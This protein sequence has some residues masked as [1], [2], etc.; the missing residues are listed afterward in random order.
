MKYIRAVQITGIILLILIVG[1]KAAVY[2]IPLNSKYNLGKVSGKYS[3]SRYL[4]RNGVVLR[5]FAGSKSRFYTWTPLQKISP[6]LINAALSGEDRNFMNHRGVYYP[7]ILRAFFQN[8][9]GGKTISGGSTITMQ[10]SKILNP[11]SRTLLNKLK[12]FFISQQIEASFDKVTILE[13]YLNLLP[14]GNGAQGVQA[15][16]HVYFQKDVSRL[17]SAESALLMI[18]PRAVSFYN[19]FRHLKRVR[20]QQKRLLEAMY[21]NGYLDKS[22]LKWSLMEEVV[23]K[24]QTPPFTAPHFTEYIRKKLLKKFPDRHVEEVTTTLDAEIQKYINGV[25]R[26]QLSKF[27]NLGMNNISCI[28]IRNDTSE[29]VG[30]VGNPYFNTENSSQIDGVLALRQPGSTLKPFTYLLE[31]INGATA[32]TIYPDVETRFELG[33]NSAY[34]PSNYSGKYLGPVTMRKALASSLN[35]PALYALRHGGV[36]NLIEVLKKAGIEDISDKPEVYGLGL[37]LGNAHVSLLSLATAYSTLARR[38]VLKKAV[39]VKKIKFTDGKLIHLESTSEKMVFPSPHVDII[40]DILSDNIARIEGFGAN[41]PFSFPVKVSV[42]TGTSNDYRDNFTVGYTSE[43]TVGVWAGNFDNSPMNSVSG[44]RG[45]GEA[46]V[47]IMKWMIQRSKNV[48][49]VKNRLVSR[50]ICPLSGMLAT[51]LCPEKISEIF[52]PGTEPVQYCDGH[53]SVFVDESS[54]LRVL[55][56][57]SKNAARGVFFRYPPVYSEW[58]KEY[59]VKTVPIWHS[60][61]TEK[62]QNEELPEIAFPIRNQIFVID[63]SLPLENQGLNLRVKGHMDHAVEWW[64]N[65]GLL[66]RVSPGEEVFWNLKKG[67]FLFRV[68]SNGRF[69][70]GVEITVK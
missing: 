25:L 34:I 58:L 53:V 44:A 7:S 43:Y 29:V 31:L 61:C 13:N 45:A 65:S 18:I 30:W 39:F 9:V 50:K 56:Q 21:E 12:E 32:A 37:T 19:P 11:S 59:N 62:K 60:V 64:V 15:A 57:C 26:Q 2:L 47:A 67:K 22:Q 38:G 66:K 16:S 8:A 5:E 3:S 40:S 52:V 33:G 6:H 42:K 27:N 54:G 70:Q 20:K 1:V 36:L 41:N 28:V 17:T 24:R 49:D 4:D 10:L 35:I 23:P 48:S 63:P 69:S 68:R 14:F 55:P 46:F 51:P